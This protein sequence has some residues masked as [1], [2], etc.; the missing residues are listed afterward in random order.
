MKSII[1]PR[2]EWNAN[3]FLFFKTNKTFGLTSRWPNLFFLKNHD[4]GRKKKQVGRLPARF[5]DVLLEPGLDFVV[6]KESDVARMSDGQNLPVAQQG[7]PW[8]EQPIHS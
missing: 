8:L 7:R 5:A 3:H 1:L 2:W 6:G 4:Q